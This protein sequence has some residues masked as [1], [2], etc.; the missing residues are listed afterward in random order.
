MTGLKKSSPNFLRGVFTALIT[1]FDK[2]KGVDFNALDILLAH[3]KKMQT[4]GIVLFASTGEF[5]ALSL[6]EKKAILSFYRSKF[7]SK[8]PQK[9]ILGC[10]E[11]TTQKVLH[12]VQL[13]EEYQADAVLIAPPY[14]NKP[15]Q[16]AII[17]HFEKIVRHC[18]IPIILY[19]NP[20]RCGVKMEI[21]TIRKIAES[22]QVIGIKEASTEPSL[23][24]ALGQH[25]P[26]HFHLLAGDEIHLLFYL[27]VGATGIIS[28]AANLVANKLKS[29]CQLYAKKTAEAQKNFFDLCPLIQALT[30]EAYPSSI[31]YALSLRNICLP[32]MRDPLIELSKKQ[33][34]IIKKGIESLLNE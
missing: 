30:C 4:D 26:S 16:K 15:N 22:P 23:W 13:A 32:H 33:E 8:A 29:I 18:P 5:W 10:T 14:Y 6:E 20:S 27:S 9:L 28:A 34:Q 24:I 1:P 17:A 2:T 31:K 25:M 21:E 7:P 12:N 19:N 11:N 3:Q